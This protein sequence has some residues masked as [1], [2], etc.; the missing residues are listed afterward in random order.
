MAVQFGCP[1]GRG[2]GVDDDGF[3]SVATGVRRPRSLARGRTRSCR[4]SGRWL[5]HW[6]YHWRCAVAL[7]ARQA[8]RLWSRARRIRRPRSR[9]PAARPGDSARAGRRRRQASAARGPTSR[10]HQLAD[11]DARSTVGQYLRVWRRHSVANAEVAG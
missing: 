5:I 2:R 6:S 4:P 8:A 7:M 9:S 11:I 10:L 3:A 1:V